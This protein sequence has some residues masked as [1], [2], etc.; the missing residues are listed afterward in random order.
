MPPVNSSSSTHDLPKIV[1]LS[2]AAQ[3]SMAD[4]WFDIASMVHFWIERRFEV[5]KRFC[6]ELI[7][8]TGELAEIGCGHGLMQ[9]QIELYYGRG[10]TGFDLNDF[11]LKHN[12]SQQSSIYC[13]DILQMDSTLK[14]KFE[15]IFLLDVLEH[16]EDEDRFLNALLFH[17]A[18]R[19]KLIV[20]VPA[21]QWAYSSYDRAVGHARRYGVNDLR[22]VALRNGLQIKDWTYWGLPLLPT[23]LI[24]KL[25]PML[26]RDQSNIVTT[27]FDPGSPQINSILKYLC[28]I[29]WIP[30]RLVG[31]SLMAI[32]QT[33]PVEEQKPESVPTSSDT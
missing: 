3:V 32:L 21:G 15:I 13:Y 14:G 2:P 8:G 19:G 17:L 23:L 24:R 4:Q 11:A 9:R 22:A 7:S 25:W 18:P 31:T 27:G 1:Y 26:S 30:Q 20:N 6:G 12:L 29:E 28:R 33:T 5:F 16:I 10:V